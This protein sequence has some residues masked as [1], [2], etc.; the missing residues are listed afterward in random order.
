MFRV[1]WRRDAATGRHVTCGGNRRVGLRRPREALFF[2]GDVCVG[3]RGQRRRRGRAR[4]NGRRTGSDAALE[5]ARARRRERNIVAPYIARFFFSFRY[6]VD[7]NGRAACE[8][9]G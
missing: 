4:S 7:R 8:R 1:R 9:K 3:G 2:L 5:K 6:F